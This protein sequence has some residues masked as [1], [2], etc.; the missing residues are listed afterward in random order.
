MA[1]VVTGIG[2][3]SPLG[4]GENSL[5]APCLSALQPHPPL[6]VLS[7]D[8]AGVAPSQGFRRF[9]KR[10]KDAKLMSPAAKLGLEAAGM[11]LDSSGPIDREE[12][13][14]F[15]AVGREPPDE[16]DAEAALVASHENG[17]LD[18]GLLATD[19][20]RLYPPLL[21]LKTL[22]NMILAHISIHLDIRG[23]NATWAGDK[24]AGLQAACS[25]YWS[26]TEGRCDAAIIGGADSLICL[27]L[28]RDRL[29]MGL[30]GYPGEAG[31]VLLLESESH[32]R[33][34][35]AEILAR[36]VHTETKSPFDTLEAYTGDCGVADALMILAQQI[37]MQE[38][39]KWG[40][41]EVLAPEANG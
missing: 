13:G 26:I 32:A 38:F 31:V 20:R 22:P 28:A 19:G 9:L 33:E 40:T 3:S 37:V 12:L 10:R 41:F 24:S 18:V 30:S 6:S 7:S 16:G 36:L 34:R 4:V 23:E 27:G 25:G 11:L 1:V 5:R 17:K 39:R 21:P 35:G 29:R 15:M 14:L 2:V 8:L